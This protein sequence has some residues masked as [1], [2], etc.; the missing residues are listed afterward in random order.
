MFMFYLLKTD[1]KLSCTAVEDE[2]GLLKQRSIAVEGWLAA[3]FDAFHFQRKY[4]KLGD[5]FSATISKLYLFV[6]L[7]EYFQLVS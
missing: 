5:L 4:E 7:A 1:S 3:T 6:S 2:I